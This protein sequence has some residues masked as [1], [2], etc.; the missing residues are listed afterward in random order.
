MKTYISQIIPKLKKYSKSLDDSALLI[1]SHWVV[2]DEINSSKRV[3]IFRPQNELLD[4]TNGKVT[5]GT[6]ELLGDNRIIIN[7]NGESFLFKNG[8]L[9]KNVCALKL[10]G[11]DHYFVLCNEHESLKELNT[12]EAAEEF[13]V[14]K[15]TKAPKQLPNSIYEENLKSTNTPREES[16]STKEDK[17]DEHEMFAIIMISVLII[18]IAVISMLSL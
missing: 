11:S 18:I 2:L 12:I 15:Y 10:D 3:F 13:L 8:F 1:N 16:Y 14:N 7:L 17:Y 9:D 4:S 6:W 5:K